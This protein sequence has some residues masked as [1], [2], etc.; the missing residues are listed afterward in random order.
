MFGCLLRTV[1]GFLRNLCIFVGI[2]PTKMRF[3]EKL[4][5]SKNHCAR[6]SLEYCFA[7]CALRSISLA[8]NRRNRAFFMNFVPK[9]RVERKLFTRTPTILLKKS[10]PKTFRLAVLGNGSAIFSALGCSPQKLPPTKQICKKHLHFSSFCY[11]ILW[12]PLKTSFAAA[13]L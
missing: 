6:F 13:F 7:V 9:K 10:L 3:F 2:E 1:S 8:S 5:F 12:E 11:T 4:C